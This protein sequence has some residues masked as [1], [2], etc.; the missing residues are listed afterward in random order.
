MESPNRLMR[1]PEA[2]LFTGIKKSSF[3]DQVRDGLLPAPVA[4][5]GKIRAWPAGELD[6][7]NAARIAGKA[8]DEIRELVVRLETSR[9]GV[10]ATPRRKPER[11]R[12]EPSAVAR[13]A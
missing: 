4:V 3:F 6:Q 11:Q 1:Q 2:S 10:P 13:P 9:T 8:D 12:G 7:I 5:G